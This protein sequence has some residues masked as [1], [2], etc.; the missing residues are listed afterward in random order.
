ML[1]RAGEN[2]GRVLLVGSALQ[3]PNVIPNWGSGD[4]GDMELGPLEKGESTGLR[5]VV[6]MPQGVV[7]IIPGRPAYCSSGPSLKAFA[8]GL[9][10]IFS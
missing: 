1:R 10:S 3:F 6:G 8:N 9:L 2:G 7:I 5:G 4:A